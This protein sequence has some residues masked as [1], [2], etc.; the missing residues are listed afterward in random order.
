MKKSTSLLLAVAGAVLWGTYGTFTTLLGKLGLTNA[1]ISM[2]GPIFIF[3]FFTALTLKSGWRNYKMPLKIIPVVLFYGCFSGLDSYAAVTAYSLLPIAVS[4]IIIYCNLFLLI[5]F[6]RILFKNKLTKEKIIACI[7]AVIGIALVVN[8]FHSDGSISPTGLLWALLAMCGWAGIVISEKY[9]LNAG[10]TGNTILSFHGIISFSFL[11]IFNSPLDF[12]HNVAT[13]FTISGWALPLTMLAF[14]LFTE[15]FCYML[16]ITA[17]KRLEPALVQIAWTMD[18][19]TS[20]VLGLIVF[21]QVLVPVQFI[22]IFVILAVVFWLHW[23]SRKEEKAKMETVTT[24]GT[25]EEQ[26]QS[27]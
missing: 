23:E 6:S 14:G 3:V 24:A 9:L 8:V 7:A 1:T 13:A 21:G 20:C 26:T 27:E 12:I 15:I 16:Y 17:L 2:I 11:S 5:I 4:S 22:G 19:V 10:V 18:P 25:N